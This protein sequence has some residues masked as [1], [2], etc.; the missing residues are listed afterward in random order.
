MLIS[1]ERKGTFIAMDSASNY[2]EI[3]VTEERIRYKCAASEPHRFLTTADGKIVDRLGRGQYLLA[4]SGIVLFS[5]D[6]ACP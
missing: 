2:Y 3:V 5:N 6:P 1:F 4:D